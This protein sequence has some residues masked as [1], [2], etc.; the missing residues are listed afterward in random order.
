MRGPPRKPSHLRLIEGT[1]RHKKANQREPNP[2]P[3]LVEP[4]DFLGPGAR[5]EWAYVA[6]RLFAL[7]LLTPIDRGPLAAYCSAVATW[8]AAERELNRLEE[9]GGTLAALVGRT[10]RDGEME[11]VLVGIVRRASRDAV[12]FGQEFGLT[13]ASRTRI[14]TRSEPGGSKFDGLLGGGNDDLE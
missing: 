5:E 8:A 2:A 9:E 1:R 10:T 11:R 13:P 4:P 14:E 7:N 6:P 12:R 3:A